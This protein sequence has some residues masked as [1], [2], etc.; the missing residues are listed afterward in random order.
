MPPREPLVLHLPPSLLEGFD[1]ARLIAAQ[2]RWSWSYGF[3]LLERFELGEYERAFAKDVLRTRTRLR[4]YRT[5]QRRGCG[6]FVAVD[7]SP[8]GPRDRVAVVIEL[9][10]GEA[11]AVDRGTRSPQLA[12]HRE[13]VEEIAEAGVLASGCEVVVVRGDPRAV[14]EVL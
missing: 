4:L 9:K 5:N 13:A 11:L 14:L 8:P 12:N 6:D 2:G 10:L 3:E 7:M 1:L